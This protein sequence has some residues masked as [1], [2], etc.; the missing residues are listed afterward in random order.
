[1]FIA[2]T[3]CNIKELDAKGDVFHWQIPTLVNEG[4]DVPVKNKDQFLY[5]VLG[6]VYEKAEKYCRVV[7]IPKAIEN[8]WFCLIIKWWNSFATKD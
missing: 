5:L 3:C 1:M 6:S 7:P 8:D 2:C 4:W